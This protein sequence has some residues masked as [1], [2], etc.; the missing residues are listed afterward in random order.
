MH[1]LIA[2]VSGLELEGL[3]VDHINRDKLDNRRENLRP[4]TNSQNQVN[5]PPKRG[6][7]FKGTELVPSGRFRARGCLNYKQVYIG[8]F[9][10]EAE[11]ARAYDAWAT[12]AHGEFAWLNFEVAA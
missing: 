4:A 7:S 6:K 2:E 3:Q 1:R 5:M 9:D 11:A 8:T 10:T 12:I